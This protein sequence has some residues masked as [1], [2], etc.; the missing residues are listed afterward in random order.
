MKLVGVGSALNPL[1]DDSQIQ[2]LFTDASEFLEEDEG[3]KA[4]GLLGRAA[5]R[6]IILERN[7]E[8]L[9]FYSYMK[10]KYN[11]GKTGGGGGGGLIRKQVSI[12]KAG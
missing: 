11:I 5:V 10:Q 3:L 7:L 9:P 1:S 2:K 12:T 8:S 6:E 4:S